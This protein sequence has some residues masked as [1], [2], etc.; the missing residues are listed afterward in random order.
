[1]YEIFDKTR[2]VLLRKRL[3]KVGVD[4]NLY[5]KRQFSMKQGSL[6]TQF[7]SNPKIG[8]S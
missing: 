3:I 7:D 4:N 6:F 5:R 2:Q 1:M 8:L